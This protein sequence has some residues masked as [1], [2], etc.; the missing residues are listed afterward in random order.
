M[1][2][3]RRNEI[4]DTIQTIRRCISIL[5]RVRTEE[6]IYHESIPENLSSSERAEESEIALDLLDDAVNNIDIGV[7]YLEECVGDAVMI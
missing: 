1:N 5:E 4:R 7:E 3:N 2:R 6:E